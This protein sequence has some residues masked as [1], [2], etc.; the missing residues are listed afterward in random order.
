MVKDQPKPGD[1]VTVA[2]RGSVYSVPKDDASYSAEVLNLLDELVKLS[3]S[4]N[5]IPPTG[6]VVVH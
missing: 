1:L 5:S 3:K 2:Y 4:I 6:T